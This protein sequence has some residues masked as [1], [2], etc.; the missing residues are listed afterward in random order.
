M[1]NH[2][3]ILQKIQTKESLLNTIKQ[4]KQEGQKIVF[5]N[6]CFDLIHRGHVDYLAK[7]SDYGTRLIVAINTD[8][9]I[10]KLKGTH[11][12]IQDQDSRTQI[13]ASMAMVDAVVLFNEET[14]LTLIQD[15]QPDVLVKGNDYKPEEII[16]YQTVKD[17][18]GTIITIDILPGFSTSNIEKKIR[19]ERFF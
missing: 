9:S 3:Q 8:A 4:W 19:F 7:A 16:G 15:I 2:Q 6:G 10:S 14:P 1:N 12:P 18:G 13:I 11:R 17:N 5:T